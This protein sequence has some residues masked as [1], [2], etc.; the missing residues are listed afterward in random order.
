LGRREA[1][2]VISIY[3]KDRFNVAGNLDRELSDRQLSLYKKDQQL[4][5]DGYPVQY[6]VGKAF[7]FEHFF[8][9]NR[10]TLIPRPETEELVALAIKRLNKFTPGA[11]LSLL[12]IGTG[13]GCIALSIKDKMPLTEVTAIDISGEAIEIARKNADRLELDVQ[14]LQLDFL[15][16]TTWSRLGEFDLIVSNPPYIGALEMEALQESVKKFEPRNA[17]VPPGSDPLIFYRESLVFME[18]HLCAG[19]AA[20]FEINPLYREDLAQCLDGS[21]KFSYS[22][23]QD[24]QG[25]D[26]ILHI[27]K[28]AG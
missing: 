18:D 23:L 5:L 25:V 3:C 14:F 20:M 17:L 24:L 27:N 16:R 19:G 7:F 4:F 11:K 9:V 15:D 2:N 10:S 13:S 6:I 22:I 21:L 12:D 26:R 8:E 1:E 28:Q